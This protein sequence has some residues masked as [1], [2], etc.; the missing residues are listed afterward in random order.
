MES[1]GS[2]DINGEIGIS[3]GTSRI[4]ILLWFNNTSKNL[5]LYFLGLRHGFKK[6]AKDEGKKDLGLEVVG[7]EDSGS[8]KR[9]VEKDL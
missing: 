7:G 9:A 5:A 1:I 3:V 8:L 4:G 2:W 6:R